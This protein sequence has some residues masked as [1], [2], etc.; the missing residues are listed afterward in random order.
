[1]RPAAGGVPAFAALLQDGGGTIE[2]GLLVL[3]C[4]VRP[5]VDVAAGAG[6]AADRGILVNHQLRAHH[7]RNVFA[8]GDGAPVR[9]LDADCR[10]GSANTGPLGL[11]GQGWQ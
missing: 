3:S 6:L 5:R 9:C 4:G 1:M 11:I 8:I 7:G 10:D 2:A